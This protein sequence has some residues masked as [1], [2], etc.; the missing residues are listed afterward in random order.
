MQPRRIILE[1]KLSPG[2]VCTLTAAVES[3]HAAYP[4]QFLTDVR[5]SCDDVFLHNPHV[6]RLADD[7]A[8]TIQ[9]HYTDAID[10]S[11]A[12]PRSFL[13]G[14]CQDLGRRLGVPLE[15]VTNRP[16]LYLSGE[17]RQWM[18]QVQQHVT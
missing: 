5:T 4:G 16:H 7:E 11:D 15:L 14:Y 10:R 13:D 2:D 18:N 8:E 9:L 17:E 6:T 1:V 12:V 3:L